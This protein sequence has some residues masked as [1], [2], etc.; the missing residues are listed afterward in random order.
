MSEKRLTLLM[1][2]VIV[3]VGLCGVLVCLFWVPISIGGW[4]IK[5]ISWKDLQTT[6]F[7]LQYAFQW[8]ISMPCFWLLIMAWKITLD[9]CEGR[10]F[11]AKNALLI[12]RATSI[13]IV[14]ILVFLI[15]NVV[16]AVLGWNG[17]LPLYIFA[18][19]VGIIFAFSLFILSQYVMQAAALQEECDL[20]V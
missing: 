20:T 9:M 4:F 15:G 13:L 6:E 19:V 8:L 7:W 12:K 11:V 18:A 14:D 3:L 1:R 2:I 5:E 16:F 10:L 17:L